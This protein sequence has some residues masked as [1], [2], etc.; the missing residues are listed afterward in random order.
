MTKTTMST[1]TASLLPSSTLTTSTV[2]LNQ[3]PTFLYPGNSVSNNVNAV[4][5]AGVAGDAGGLCVVIIIIVSL[6][7]KKYR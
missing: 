1:S 6:K 4:S 3:F 2:L 7:V 5:V